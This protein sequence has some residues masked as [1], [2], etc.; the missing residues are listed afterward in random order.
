MSLI[1]NPRDGQNGKPWLALLLAVVLVWAP[2]PAAAFDGERALA[3][4]RQQ[5][6]LGPRVPGTPE[7]AQGRRWILDRLDEL[8]LTAAQTTFTAHLALNNVNVEAVNLWGLPSLSGPTSPA[9]IL[10]AHWDTR[11]WADRDPSGLN[12]PMLG[13]NDGGSGVAVALEI[14]RELRNSPLR[15]HLALA[16]WDAEDAGVQY[17]AD[18]WCLGARYAAAHPPKWVNRVALGINL[19]LV[20]GVDMKL[21]PETHSLEAAPWAV[22]GVWTIGLD[23]HP[24]WFANDRTTG[25]IDDHLPWIEA[26]VAFIDLIGLPYQWWHTAGDT[27]EHCSAAALAAV[28]EVVMQYIERGEWKQHGPTNRARPGAWSQIE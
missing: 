2:R 10:S 11:P 4:V 24:Q 26:G 19:D 21:R 9:L 28:G 6:A 22:G 15:E 12:P 23:L 5:C 17:S 18:S 8:G 20:G 14:A 25:Y 16:F 3:L 27:P 13:A 7:H 1:I